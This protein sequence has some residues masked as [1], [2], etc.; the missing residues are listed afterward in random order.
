VCYPRCV[1]I[2][3]V[4]MKDAVAKVC[5]GL[6]AEAVRAREAAFERFARWEAEHPTRYEP[7]AALAAVTALYDLLPVESRHRAP[8]PEGVMAFHALLS[9]TKPTV[10]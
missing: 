8:D 6:T 9:R 5:P 2:L 10:R 1:K 7:A 4:K 3:P